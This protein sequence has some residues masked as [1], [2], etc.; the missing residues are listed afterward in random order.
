MCHWVAYIG[1]T[2][3]FLKVM[4]LGEEFGRLIWESKREE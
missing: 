1:I 3:I 4:K 2:R